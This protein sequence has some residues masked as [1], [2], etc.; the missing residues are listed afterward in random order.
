MPV[1]KVDSVKVAKKQPL[2]YKIL[3]PFAYRFVTPIH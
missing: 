3:V 1:K 2:T